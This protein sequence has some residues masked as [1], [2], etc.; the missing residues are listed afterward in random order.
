MTEETEA[1]RLAHRPAPEEE[2]TSPDCTCRRPYPR[3]PLEGRTWVRPG[4]VILT[5]HHRLCPWGGAR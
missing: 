5:L 3:R 4:A 1:G 2:L